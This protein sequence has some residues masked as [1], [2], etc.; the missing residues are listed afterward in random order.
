[1]K[2]YAEHDKDYQG[3][4]GI[5]SFRKA[6]TDYDASG[7]FEKDGFKK[8]IDMTP[9]RKLHIDIG[10]GGGWLLFKT[11]PFFEKVIGVEPSKTACDNV[12]ILI[13]EYETHNVELINSDM[14]DAIKNLHLQTPAFFTTVIVLSHIKDFYVK[15]FLQLLNTIPENSTL[16]FCERYDKNM[17]QNLWHIRRKYWWAK[18]LSEWHLEF[19]DIEANGYKSGIFGKKIGN[20]NI[21]NTFTPTIKEN[22]LWLIDG[23]KQKILRVFRFIKRSI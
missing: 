13:K 4:F 14:I 5:E 7:M 18:N 2:S 1:M 21:T 17:Q 3:Q 8:A 23:I 6:K 10:S 12:S 9:V 11:S 20:A 22:I 16:Y 19:F 15:E